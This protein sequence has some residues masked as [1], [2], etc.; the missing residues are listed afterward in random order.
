MKYKQLT[1]TEF[2]KLQPTFIE[3]LATK[4]LQPSDW[5]R[6]IESSNAKAKA[7]LESFSDQVWEARLDRIEYVEHRNP[8]T[9]RVYRCMEKQIVVNILQA[10]EEEV[11]FT[12]P[13]SLSQGQSFRLE[14]QEQFYEA[15]ERNAF[16]FDLIKLGA[17]PSSAERFEQLAS[18]AKR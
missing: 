14:Q 4:G 1:P 15:E 10:T 2:Q 5:E 8:R 13:E 16:I 12:K 3:F 17:R 18:L 9:W 7:L 6:I 11:D